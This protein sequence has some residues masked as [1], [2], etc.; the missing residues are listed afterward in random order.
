V[1]QRQ[2]FLLAAPSVCHFFGLLYASSA[3]LNSYRL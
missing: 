3:S 1:P 2:L